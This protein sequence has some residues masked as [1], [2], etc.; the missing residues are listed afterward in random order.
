MTITYVLMQN[1]RRNLL[2]TSLT[3]IAFALP[4]AVFVAAISFVVTLAEL[5]AH[6]EQELRLGV[7]HRTTLTN[8]LPEGHRRKIEGLDP[9]RERLIAVCG[10]KWFGGRVPNSQNTLTSLAADPDTF[11]IV[12]SD[13]AMQPDEIEAWNKDRQAC[14]VGTT[15]AQNYGWK[16][17]DRLTL[18][19]TVPPYLSLEFH[20]VKIITNKERANF[21]WFRRD[22]LTESLET[23]GANDARCNIFW[24][25]CRSAESLRSLQRDIDEMFANTPD[26]TKSED[27]NAFAA[28][29][30]QAAGNIPGLMQAMAIVVVVIIGLVAGNTMM[31]SF[32]E[33]MR[34]LAVFKAIGFQSGRIFFIVI[35]ESI[36]LALI[37]SLLGV[38]PMWGILSMLPIARLVNFGPISGFAVSPVAV[39]GSICIA[40][41]VGVASG[42]WPAYRAMRLRTT[43]AL[44]RVA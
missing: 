22:Y 1:L 33:R 28:N 35:S 9:N 2:R 20:I 19:S 3:V 12:Y 44:R 27:E 17:G 42:M 15:P 10:M 32:R 24:V 37:G 38:L 36:L 7:H 14:V 39:V 31:M 13:T 16:V 30:T 34:E 26:A 18:D 41:L 6:N 23:A 4:M 5:A 29:F 43:D 11:P 21:F 40:L 8:G 25:K